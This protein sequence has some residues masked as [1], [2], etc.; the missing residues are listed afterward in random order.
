MKKTETNTRSTTSLLP[1]STQQTHRLSDIRNRLWPRD[2]FSDST[3][4][5]TFQSRD[6]KSV[7]RRV[8]KDHNRSSCFASCEGFKDSSQPFSSSSSRDHRGTD[9]HGARSGDRLHGQGDAEP[10]R[11][12]GGAQGDQSF[13]QQGLYGAEAGAWQGIRQKIYSEPEC[14]YQIIFCISMKASLTYLQLSW[15]IKEWVTGYSLIISTSLA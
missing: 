8:A 12:S 1:R 5:A 13:Y 9:Q 15:I 7:H 11:H 10:Q 4:P 2:T 3:R 14:K 6:P